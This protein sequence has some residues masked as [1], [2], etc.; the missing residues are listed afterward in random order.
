MKLTKDLIADTGL[1]R[2]ILR[3]ES[4]RISALLL[5]PE[6]V[7]RSV[8]FH[9][10]SLA[11]DSIRSLEN[12]IYENPL[13]LG[14]F[15]AIDILF[16]NS[17]AFLSPVSAAEIREQMAD[18]MLPDYSSPRKIDAEEV[19]NTMEV[20]YAVNEDAYNFV[21]RTFAAARFHHSMAINAKYL[22]HRNARSGASA[23]LFALCEGQDELVNIAFDAAGILCNLSRPKVFT[24]EDCAY[25]ILA[26]SNNNDTPL[27]VGGEPALRNEVCNILRRMRPDATVLPLTLPEDLLQ[28]RHLA[29]E[30]NFDMIFLTQL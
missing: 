10:E 28:L 30:A 24:A 6:S 25:F 4:Q 13:I 11:D 2:L 8:L 21:A 14:D 27:S 3:I 17:E 5:G 29:P 15:A 22:Y 23:H 1:W 19:T 12:A 26:T 9:S 16:A 20:V 7:E 18:A